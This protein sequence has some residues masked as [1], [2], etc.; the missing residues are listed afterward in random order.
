MQPLRQ[1]YAWLSIISLEHP[2]SYLQI[3]F[4][5]QSTPRRPSALSVLLFVRTL[6]ILGLKSLSD[7]LSLCTPH[8]ANTRPL[9]W[10][11][12][13]LLPPAPCSAFFKLSGTAV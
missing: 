7:D 2:P 5:P 12:I 4:P 13:N 11:T 6:L 8:L 1:K 9:R 3:Q 10:E